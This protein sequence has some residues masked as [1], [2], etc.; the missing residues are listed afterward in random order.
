MVELPTIDCVEKLTTAVNKPSPFQAAVKLF[1]N[2]Y[3]SRLTT[4][5]RFGFK[6][7]LQKEK[8]CDVSPLDPEER[9]MFISESLN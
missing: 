8:C 1:D 4:G 9:Q 3:A 2:E 5:E 6:R 7:I